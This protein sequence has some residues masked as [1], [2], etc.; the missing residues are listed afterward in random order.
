MPKPTFYN[1]NEEKRETL[2]EA[3]K[4]EFS[5]V[6]LYDASISNI[7][8]KACIPRGSF[9]QYFEDKEDAFFYLLNEHA[10]D[11]HEHF[12]QC[13][14]TQDGDLFKAMADL[15]QTALEQSQEEG[16][17]NYLRNVLLN[18]NYKI[19]KEVTKYIRKESNDS[20]FT[21][22][23]QLVDL[24][25]LNIKSSEQLFHIF[26]IVIAI[27]FHNLVQCIANDYT[28]EEAMDKYQKEIRMIQTGL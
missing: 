9:Y 4:E 24:E 18:K 26:E 21:Q 27:T 16:Q 2:I 13:L 28:Q 19:E 15:F 5:R 10:K 25:G 14:K 6:S 1:L 20:R 8:K 23:S 3:A 11:Q 7:L 22:V 12:L 17:N